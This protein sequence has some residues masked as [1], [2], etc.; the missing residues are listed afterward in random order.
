MTIREAIFDLG[1]ERRFQQHLGRL[2]LP[3]SFRDLSPV[4]VDE[5]S[6]LPAPARRFMEFVRVTERPRARSF[7]ARFVGEIRMRPGQRWMP[8]H[9]RQYNSVDP[10]VR[11][12]DM[13]IDVAGVVPMFG[14]DT[15]LNGRGRMHGK[16]LGLVTV[17]DGE[18][19]EFDL[20][21]LVTWVNDA[22]LVAPSM[23]LTSRTDWRAVD[24]DSFDVIFSDGGNTVTAR[25]SVD[26]GG[27]LTDFHTDDR[28]YAGEP[29]PQRMPWSTPISGWSTDRERPVPL[30]AEAVWHFADDEFAYVRGRFVQDSIVYNVRLPTANPVRERA[31]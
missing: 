17:A 29:S 24:D 20:G 15:Y 10:V 14:S 26:G 30:D 4:S 3:V 22:A 28:W 2:A 16:L 18:G 19:R 21:E 31:L 7:R 6:G 23:L 1:G 12:I 8:F 5:L 11:V 9:A 13:R 27:R 25:L